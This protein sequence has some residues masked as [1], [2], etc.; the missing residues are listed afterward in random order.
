MKKTI[1]SLG[2]ILLFIPMAYAD[3]ELP[4]I[5]EFSPPSNKFA[6]FIKIQLPEAM[7]STI[8]IFS[9]DERVNLKLEQLQ[10]RRIEIEYFIKKLN[11]TRSPAFA[12]KYRV[13]IKHVTTQGDKQ[14]ATLEKHVKLIRAEKREQVREFLQERDD[15]LTLLVNTFLTTENVNAIEGI[16]TALNL[17]I[18]IRE[19][20]ESTLPT[21]ARAGNNNGVGTFQIV[22]GEI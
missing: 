18:R 10:K 19:K 20:L 1:L 21:Q 2:L 9:R 16:R 5:D 7:A 12:E 17:S 11:V 22:T 15:R 8:A 4:D 13:M 6:Y 14:I 3:I